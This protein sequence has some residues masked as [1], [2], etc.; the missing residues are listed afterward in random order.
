MRSRFTIPPTRR[1][2]SM[3]PAANTK[4]IAYIRFGIVE[5][6]ETRSKMQHDNVKFRIVSLRFIT[7]S[8][9]AS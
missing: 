2:I 3:T 5:F 1:N 7:V 9:I 6:V 4:L 8:V